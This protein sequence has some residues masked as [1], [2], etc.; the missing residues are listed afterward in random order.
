MQE[1]GLESLTLKDGSAVKVKQLVQASIPVKHRETAFQWLRDRGHGDLI[2]NQIS[3]EFGKGEDQSA[4][5]FIE[6]IKS[7]GYEPK[8]KV[9]VEPMTLKAFVR[10][11]ISRRCGY[12][13]GKIRVS[14]LVPKLKLVKCD[15]LK[16][17]RRNYGKYKRCK[18]RR[19][20]NYRRFKS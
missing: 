11:Q 4:G 5:K 12:T 1:L 18:K 8:Q 6:N 20:Q 3:A 19:K 9:W 15:Y 14:L 2:K 13:Y 16:S 10:E 7:L 17:K